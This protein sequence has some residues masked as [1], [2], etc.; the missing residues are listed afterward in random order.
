MV[1][2]TSGR[3]INVNA[4]KYAAAINARFNFIVAISWD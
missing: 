1:T 4:T 2:S 3:M